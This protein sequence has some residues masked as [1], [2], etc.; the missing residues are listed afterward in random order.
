MGVY[1]LSSKKNVAQD[2]YKELYEMEPSD[3]KGQWNARTWYYKQRLLR[4]VMSLFELDN[5]PQEWDVE[6]FK[7][8]LLLT[9][10]MCVGNTA[11][12]GV[13]PMRCTYHGLNQFDRPTKCTISNHWIHNLTLEIGKDCVLVHLQ[14]NYQ[15]IWTLLNIY[16][17][18]LASIDAGIEVNI[19]NTKAAWMFDCDGKAQE[20]TAKKIYDDITSGRPAVFARANNSSSLNSDGKIGI[21]MLNVK[22]TYIAD[23][24]QD[25]KR[26]VRY[27]FLS[28][29]GINNA[30]VDKKERVNTLEVEANDDEL[31]NAVDDWKNNL[32]E[33]FDKI[34]KMFGLDIKVK[35]PYYRTTEDINNEAKAQT[36]TLAEAIAL[37]GKK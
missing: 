37:R 6:W 15:G 33:Q 26:E 10:Y 2:I 9:G 16:A 28:E 11:A 14:N 17:E 25:A 7:K 19:M 5:C 3:V 24:L 1:T 30:N 29:I 13:I 27:E 20:D 18:K 31:R 35:F 12:F 21:T 34:N 36:P 23:L 32:E 4:R 8:H 22:N